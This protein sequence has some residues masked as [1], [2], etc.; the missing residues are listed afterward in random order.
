M[1]SLY[2]RSYQEPWMQ[3][4]IQMEYGGNMETEYL[5]GLHYEISEC[6]RCG[7]L[8][9]RDAPNEEGGKR[10]FEV[11]IKPDLTRQSMCETPFN[12]KLARATLSFAARYLHRP[13]LRMLDYGAGSGH[14]CAYARELGMNV[15]AVENAAPYF[16]ALRLRGF[17]PLS[18]G[19]EK[20]GHYDFVVCEQVI[21]HV[22]DPFKIVTALYRALRDDGLLF[23]EVHNCCN[24][25]QTLKTVNSLPIRQFKTALEPCAAVQHMNCFTNRTLK[26]ICRRAGFKPVF[27][28]ILFLR[29]AVGWET[30]WQIP[31]DLARPFYRHFFGTSLFFRKMT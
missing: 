16:E 18:P 5:A 13:R 29:Q 27:R 6:R 22:P 12:R 7:F 15:S 26:Q 30:P 14:L 4:Y 10:I 17:D 31:K 24:V 11:W 3:E 19:Q 25:R 9:Q 23:L 1:V 28:P 20:A 21:E 2:K 8:F